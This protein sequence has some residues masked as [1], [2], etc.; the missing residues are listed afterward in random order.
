M[1]KPSELTPEQEDQEMARRE[2]EEAEARSNAPVPRW[3]LIMAINNV[4]RHYGANGNHD[5]DLI[6]NAFDGLVEELK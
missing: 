4:A 5:S 3:E 2:R 6:S 1:T